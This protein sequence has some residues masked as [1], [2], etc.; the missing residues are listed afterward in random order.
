[1]NAKIGFMPSCPLAAEYINRELT[2][3]AGKATRLIILAGEV[4]EG[5]ATA[6]DIAPAD[7]G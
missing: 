4:E 7:R 2:P 5:H 3:L 6:A 1:M